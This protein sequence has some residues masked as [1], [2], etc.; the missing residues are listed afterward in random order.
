MLYC[1]PVKG[2]RHALAW[3]AAAGT[4]WGLIAG[5]VAC[6]RRGASP[7]AESGRTVLWSTDIGAART[8]SALA[9]AP[10]GT[11][12]VA[13]FAPAEEP[14]PGYSS[15]DGFRQLCLYAL[16]AQ[17]QITRRVAGT[18]TRESPEVWVQ[19][20]SWGA[21]M[22]VDA[23]GGLYGLLP[24]GRERFNPAGVSVSG[25]P[26]IGPRGEMYVGGTGG[27]KVLQ[28]EGNEPLDVFASTG[29]SFASPPALGEDGSLYFVSSH[30][31]R[32]YGLSAGGD[33]LW[34]TRA[35][36]VHRPVLAGDRLCITH[37][38]WLSAFATTGQLMWEFDAGAPL[39]TAPAPAPD[40]TVYVATESGLV[41]AVDQGS[42]RWSFPLEL[43]VAAGLSVDSEG[44]LFVSDRRGKVYA[45][46]PDGERR[47]T[48]EIPPP[49][50]TPVPGPDGTVY[51]AAGDGRV[52]AIQVASGGA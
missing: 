32:F 12:Y 3:L 50:G 33:V 18:V 1:R 35:R 7:P 38:Q 39:V 17:G 11:I 9:V 24:A 44:A 41:Y 20:S 34:E 16:D 13:G 52:Y 21:G 25:P 30:G 51:V 45:I 2:Q 40:G 10:D 15:A 5:G 47:W 49:A 19:V 36:G 27:L 14:P 6:R 31:G 46:G 22:A 42:K 23:E 4:F 43:P 28:L 8:A 26:A 29:S 37:G 48:F